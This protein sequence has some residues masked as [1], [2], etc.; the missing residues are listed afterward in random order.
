MVSAVKKFLGD[1]NRIPWMP[2][3]IN[4]I[5]DAALMKDNAPVLELSNRVKYIVTYFKNLLTLWMN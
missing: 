1:N 4:L 5:V 2:H 3:L